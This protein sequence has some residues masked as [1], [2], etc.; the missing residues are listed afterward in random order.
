MYFGRSCSFLIH[1]DGYCAVP[2]V[3]PAAFIFQFVPVSAGQS[4]G[5]DDAAGLRDIAFELV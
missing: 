3:T 4:I 1:L 5:H 2:C